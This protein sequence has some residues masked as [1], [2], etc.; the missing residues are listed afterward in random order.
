[1]LTVRADE[2]VQSVP[3]FDHLLVPVDFSS[4]TKGLLRHAEALA[5][6]Y[7]VPLHL[8]HVIEQIVLPTA[9]GIQPP[10]V[11]LTDMRVKAREALH[12]HIDQ[13]EDAG[14]DVHLHIREGHPAQEILNTVSSCSGSP[15]LV[16]ATHGRTG[17]KRLLLGSVA[18][19]V[20]RRAD[21]PVFTVKPFGRALTDPLPEP[22][23]AGNTAAPSDAAQSPSVS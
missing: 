15:L 21:C 8:L 9:Y 5:L 22:A 4:H 13:L 10:E 3:S 12:E 18:E 11:D 7:D 17:F 20:V 2:D 16:I 14:V 1:V 19:K 23:D 6:A